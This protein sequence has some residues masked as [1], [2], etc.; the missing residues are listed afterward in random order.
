MPLIELIKIIDKLFGTVICLLL[1]I[2]NRRK[3]GPIKVKRILFIQLWSIGETIL[4]L[5]ATRHIAEEYKKAELAVLCTRRNRDVYESSNLDLK[6]FCIKMNPLSILLFL[7]RNFRKFDLVIDYE[8]YLNI[9]AIIAYFVGKYRVGFSHGNRGKTYTKTIPYNSEQHVI[10]TFGELAFAISGKGQLQLQSLC[11]NGNE[12]LK[13]LE[14]GYLVGFVPGAAESGGSRMWPENNYV[15]LARKLLKQKNLKIVLIG[16]PS[17]REKLETIRKEINDS[18]AINMAGQI[19]VTGLFCLI[20]RLDVLITN[21]T[22]PLHIASVEKTKTIALFG[23][24]TP[25]RFGPYETQNIVLY[26]PDSC[27]YSPCINVHLGMVPDC[28]FA[29]KSPDYQKCM[30]SI[31]VE[32][33]YAAFKQLA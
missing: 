22:G 10:K 27:R 33:V 15:E 20:R 4:T 11:K 8:E 21:D 18:R 14:Q 1:S 3:P 6:I 26:R 17:E 19:T 23:P 12:C 9:S 29:T 5:P 30:K 24:N 13:E 28:L 16:S 32:D 7:L 31:S 2:V 25:V